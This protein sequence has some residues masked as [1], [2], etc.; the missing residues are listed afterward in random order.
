MCI[1]NL[2][3]E[4]ESLLL[5]LRAHIA[6]CLLVAL[7]GTTLGTSPVSAQSA[8]ATNSS[9]ALE[10]YRIGPGDVLSITLT[11]A[12]EFGGKSRVS[13]AGVIQIAGVNDPLTAEGLTPIELSQSIR[14]ALIDAKQ[15]RDPKVNV[16]IDE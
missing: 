11:D 10:E 13:D 15:L 12:P 8:A 9:A 14:K 5:G 2:A 3:S 1:M 16:F 6:L 7:L 4:S